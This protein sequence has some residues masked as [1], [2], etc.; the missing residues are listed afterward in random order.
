[1]LAST[2]AGWLAADLRSLHGKKTRI[3]VIEMSDSTSLSSE[4]TSQS[5]IATASGCI[6]SALEYCDFFIYAQAVALSYP[7]LFV[8]AT[9]PK[10]AIVFSLATYRACNGSPGR[11][12]LPRPLG[13]SGG[14]KI[15]LLLCMMLMGV[16][17]MGGP[18]AQLSPDRHYGYLPFINPSPGARLRCRWRD[19][20]SQ[21]NDS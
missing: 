16:A 1:M 4:K 18:A 3:T 19:I 14:R 5:K 21:F 7:Q 10:V 20:G 12:L 9:D 6:G 17:T 13:D 2:W 8:P 11:S 15:A